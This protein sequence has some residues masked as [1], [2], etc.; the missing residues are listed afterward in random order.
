M[1]FMEYRIST[2]AKSHGDWAANPPQSL[3]DRDPYDENASRL[4]LPMIFFGIYPPQY[5]TII[6]KY[7]TQC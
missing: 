5:I 4:K 1:E 3:L 7:C 2:R 6:G